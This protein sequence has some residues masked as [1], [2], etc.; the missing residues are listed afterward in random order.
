[1]LVMAGCGQPGVDR[2]LAGPHASGGTDDA[3]GSPAGPGGTGT[4]GAGDTA[5]AGEANSGAGGTGGGGTTSAGDIGPSSSACQLP[6]VSSEQVCEATAGAKCYYIDAETGDDTAGDGTF[7]KPWRSLANVVS[8][9][10][11]PSEN[12]STPAPATAVALKPGDAVYLFTGSYTDTYDYSGVKQLGRFRNLHGSAT[13]RFRLKA[14]PGQTPVLDAG[15]EARAIVLTQVSSWEISGIEIKNARGAGLTLEDADDVQV[16]HVHIHDTDGVDNDNIAGLYVVGTTNVDIACSELHDNY[17]REN[18]DTDGQ[19]T[20]NSSNL[21][22]FG[23]GDVRI[24][25]SHFWQTPD[26]SAAKTGGC[27][28][29]KHAASVA[30]GKF[31]VDHNELAS[32]KFFAIGTGTQHSHVHHNL[33][34]HGAGLVSRDFGGPT[35]QT[36]QLFEYNSMYLTD[37]LELSPT[38]QWRDGTFDD[39]EAIVFSHNIVVRDLATPTA[40]YAT[41]VIGTYAS[42]AL[43]DETTPELSFESNCYFNPSGSPSFALFAANGGNYGQKGDQHSLAEWQGLGYDSGSVNEPPLF[44]DAANGNLEPLAASPCVAMGAYAP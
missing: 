15:G 38:D 1:M 8:Y 13:Q 21:V 6:P 17:D 10:G 23:G 28:K 27:I 36:D 26:P 31:E 5:R 2:T 34:S 14:Y 42:D 20:E 12:G 18:A 44:T 35:H 11:T 30:E 19:A 9:Y 37:G 22:V 25:H 16:S 4:S 29:Y 33:I 40:E 7:A 43:F 32:C 41:I 24:H 3:G 39:P